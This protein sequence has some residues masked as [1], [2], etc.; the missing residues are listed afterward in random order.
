MAEANQPTEQNKA[1]QKV[2]VTT[3]YEGTGSYYGEGYKIHEVDIKDTKDIFSNPLYNDGDGDD[4][5]SYG[6]GIVLIEYKGNVVYSEKWYYNHIHQML[7]NKTECNILVEA[8]NED[9]RKQH[10]AQQILNHE[11]G[12]GLE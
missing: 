4:T 10:A 7:R 1:E 2:L 5:G 12:R 11:A 3:H 9:K 6:V 8:Y